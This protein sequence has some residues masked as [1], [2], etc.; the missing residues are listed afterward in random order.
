MPL[1]K[2]ICK[3]LTKNEGFGILGLFFLA[4]MHLKYRSTQKYKL[5]MISDGNI[6]F[7]S[8]SRTYV[9]FSFVFSN[10]VAEFLDTVPVPARKLKTGCQ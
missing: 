9:S 3:Q 8:A 7:T 6:S 5:K 10:F 2:G 4:E 1:G